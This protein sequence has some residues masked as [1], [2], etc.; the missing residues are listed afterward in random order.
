MKECTFL[1]L[2][3]VFGNNQIDIIKKY[4]NKAI[5]TDFSILLGGFVLNNCHL[6]RFTLDDRTGMWFTKSFY[7]DSNVY[8]VDHRGCKDI[9]SNL[10]RQCGARPVLLWNTDINKFNN[11][12]IFEEHFGEYPQSIAGLMEQFLLENLYNL[13]ELEETGKRYVV[14]S[15]HSRDSNA[16]FMKRDL[17]EYEY[18]GKK[19]I[20]FVTDSFYDREGIL[21]DGTVVKPS[22][23]YWIKVEPITW[24]FDLKNKMAL[25]K[26]ILFSGIQFNNYE[27]ENAL[28]EE[29]DIYNFLNNIFLKDI[30][31]INESRKK[32]IYVSTS[33]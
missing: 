13:N 11:N 1:T 31:N 3:D 6:D 26:K 30:I 20:R 24:L 16:K 7:D 15:Y 27:K 29:S 9:T 17:V 18:N 28:F 32:L 5:I 2:T 14:D 10:K 25:S 12:E 22:N 4:G 21:S 23:V 8:Y 19:Y 33:H